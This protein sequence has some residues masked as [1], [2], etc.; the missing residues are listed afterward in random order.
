MD[1]YEQQ[2]I[3]KSVAEVK[4]STSSQSLDKAA[5]DMSKAVGGGRPDSP[6]PRAPR[7]QQGAAGG[8]AVQRYGKEKRD[9]SSLAIK[10]AIEEVKTGAM[11]SPYTPDEP[12]EP[13]WV[14]RQDVSPTR[15]CDDQR[16]VDG[17][18]PSPSS[19]SPMGAVFEHIPS[20]Q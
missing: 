17:D 2:D 4:Q 1:S 11:C 14:M 8:E 9:A 13:I 18:S 20:S 16:P 10:G 5:D 19:S 12:R 7:G 3:D 6:R 15:D